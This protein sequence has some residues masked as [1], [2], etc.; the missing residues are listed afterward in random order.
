MIGICRFFIYCF[1]SCFGS[2]FHWVCFIELSRFCFSFVVLSLF[3]HVI[4][5]LCRCCFAFSRSAYLSRSFLYCFLSF[6]LFVFCCVFRSVFVSFARSFFRSFLL[7]L[8][9]FNLCVFHS[10]DFCRSLFLAFFFCFRSF[11]I[12]FF[13]SFVLSFILSSCLSCCFFLFFFLSSFFLSSLSLSF[14]RSFFLSSFLPFFLSLSPIFA[15]LK[16]FNFLMLIYFFKAYP[17]PPR[18]SAYQGMHPWTC[19]H[20]TCPA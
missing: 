13:L 16:Q 15:M 8:F 2:L 17:A 20:R 18:S 14:F 19:P 9:L 12:S 5:C 3:F 1:L 10:C 6:F 11:F 4:W 7:W